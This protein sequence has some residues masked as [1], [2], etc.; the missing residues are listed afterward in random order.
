MVRWR[1]TLCGLLCAFGV[2]AWGAEG[3]EEATP[4]AE[5][6]EFLAD[7]QEVD[8]ETFQLLL[9]HGRRD[10]GEEAEKKDEGD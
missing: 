4:S 1:I 8:D 3:A 9:E 10:A 6:L 5:L 2:S 7:W